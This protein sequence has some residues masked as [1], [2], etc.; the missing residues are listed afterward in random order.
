MTELN[1]GFVGCGTHS[2][3]NLYP[4]LK[5]SRCRLQAVCDMKRELAEFNCRVFGGRAVYTDVDEM[6]SKEALDGVMVVG[7]PIMHYEV[8]KKVLARGIPLFVEKPP[9][10]TLQQ[11]EELAMMAR[12][13]GT[14]VMT[15]FM[16]RWGLAYRKI[17]RF[18]DEGRFVPHAG[19]FRYLHWPTTNLKWMLLGMSIHP[20]DLAISFFGDVDAVTST[21]YETERAVSLGLTLRFKSGRWAHLNLGSC[22]PRIQERMELTGEMDGKPT[23]LV[24]DNVQQLEIHTQG[25]GGCDL[26]P[27]LALI[28]PDFSMEDIQVWRP[29]Y[30]LPNIKQNS[31]FLQGVCT[32]RA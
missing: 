12:A 15:G 8:G 17:R 6:L 26:N 20:I 18:V 1:I 27:D 31:P 25:D 13:A 22:A 4:M 28:D 9:A 16:K 24:V 10:E 29:D 5:Y 3:N 11:A 19:T 7:P 2:T 21:T 14:F 23:L 30:G 32:A